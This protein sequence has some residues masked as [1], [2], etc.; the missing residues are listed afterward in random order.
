M[1][2]CPS[3]ALPSRAEIETFPEP[4]LFAEVV[5]LLRIGHEIPVWLGTLIL[6]VLEKQLP[7]DPSPVPLEDLISVFKYQVQHFIL[8]AA[9]VDFVVKKL[10]PP[11]EPLLVWRLTS[12]QF[13]LSV[14][15]YIIKTVAISYGKLPATTG[16]RLLD[17]FFPDKDTFNLVISLNNF[18]GNAER[19]RS[20]PREDEASPPD[21]DLN[22]VSSLP[23]TKQTVPKES[24]KSKARSVAKSSKFPRGTFSAHL[25]K[26]AHGSRPTMTSSQTTTHKPVWVYEVIDPKEVGDPYNQNSLSATKVPSDPGDSVVT[27]KPDSRYDV[28]DLSETDVPS[29]REDQSEADS[30][31]EAGAPP[32]RR[33]PKGYQA[34]RRIPERR[35]RAASTSDSDS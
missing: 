17:I 32:P 6:Q 34:T 31:S 35:R 30:S 25:F 23:G 16:A 11:R 15:F 28:N 20:P 3:F 22:R 27:N 4:P 2:A 33:R 5:S 26:N 1:F 29:P 9:G 21:I 7:T 24:D 13:T 18:R 14:L 10:K 19:T 12:P 8:Q